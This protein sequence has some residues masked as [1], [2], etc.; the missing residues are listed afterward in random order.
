MPRGRGRD[1]MPA[2]TDGQF[3]RNWRLLL[4]ILLRKS[5][6]GTITEDLTEQE[7]AEFFEFA[8][9]QHLREPWYRVLAEQDD[10]PMVPDNEM[11][12][13]E[14][15]MQMRHE[16][17][18]RLDKLLHALKDILDAAGI[19]FV[20][21]KGPHYANRYHDGPASRHYDDLDILVRGADL[22]RTIR[23]LKKCGFEQPDRRPFLEG[24][25]RRFEH[26]VVL[27]RDDAKL[28]LHWC[29]RNR[30]GYRLDMDR[31]WREA[32]PYEIGGHPF[33]VPSDEYVLL[34]ILLEIGGELESGGSR[35]KR[36]YDLY[37]ILETIGTALS[38][39]E[40]FDARRHDNTLGLVVNAFAVFVRLFEVEERYPALA[41][42]IRGLDHLVIIETREQ[43]IALVS[44]PRGSPEGRVWF[45]RS[46][47][48]NPFRY[49]AWQALAF[50]FAR[51]R[52]R[53][54]PRAATARA[55]ASYLLGYDRTSTAQGMVGATA[56]R[57][58]VGSHVATEASETR[59]RRAV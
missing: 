20:V 31:F 19:E 8:R 56:K 10:H 21:L 22:G 37:R 45:A 57:P 51:S 1:A 52:A 42:A 28:D 23:T 9:N 25:I 50:L 59:E 33:L 4:H 7:V 40:F 34:S 49:F 39:A 35:L 3:V 29:I 17:S 44:A 2:E 18:E 53:L 43:A 41:S 26:A 16:T 12:R 14:R 32:R 58:E 13:L 36:Y 46:I 30:P 6:I 48:C 55:V 47:E 24:V 54:V 11:H 15:Y 5:D 38:W 27:Q